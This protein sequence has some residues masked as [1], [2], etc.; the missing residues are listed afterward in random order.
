MFRDNDQGLSYHLTDEEY[1]FMDRE[2][3]DQTKPDLDSGC[4][5][6]IVLRFL[7]IRNLF[8]L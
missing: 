6:K 2:G 5:H 1:S 7:I 8:R 4:S 3:P